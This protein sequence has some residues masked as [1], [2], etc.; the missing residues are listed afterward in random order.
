MDSDPQRL[1]TLV[2]EQ[3]RCAE[4]MLETLNRENQALVDGDASALSAATEAKARL[5]DALEKLE[6][7][8]HAMATRDGT[9]GAPE[10]LRLRAIISQCKEQN[11]RNGLLLKARAE[12]VRIALKTLRGSEP[13]LYSATG[14]TP[15]RADARTLGTA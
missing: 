5:V 6:S 3:L 10:S 14:R 8:R 1:S 2:G 7:E 11:Q 12:N 9:V 4:A 15:S 13:E